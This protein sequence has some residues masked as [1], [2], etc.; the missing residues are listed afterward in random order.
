MSIKRLRRR[1]RWPFAYGTARVLWWLIQHLP[2]SLVRRLARLFGGLLF[3]L[4]SIRRLILAN[5]ELAFPD[6]PQAKREGVGRRSLDHLMTVYMEFIWYQ[7][8]LHRLTAMTHFSSD[9]LSTFRAAREADHPVIFCSPHLGSWEAGFVALNSHGI[10]AAAVARD[11][12][13]PLLD[14]FFQEQRTIAGGSIIREKGA[15]RGMLKALRAA[16]PLFLLVDQNTK[17]HQGG[18]FATF[19]GVPASMSRGPAMLVQRTDA[20]LY[21]CCCLRQPDGQYHI[22]TR[23]LLSPG[24]HDIS[25]EAL[26]ERLNRETEKLVHQH[27]EQYVWLYERWRYLPPGYDGDRSIFPYYAKP[28]RDRK[29]EQQEKHRKKSTGQ[30]ASDQSDSTV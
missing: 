2:L 30:V 17:P 27:P 16:T 15:V 19:F 26:G 24:D 23:C 29:R 1:L 21:I 13:N 9:S 5:L 11:L 6:W 28:Y 12:N 18:M 14:R 10:E 3:R 25:D 8:R 4:P 7:T 20:A 22:H